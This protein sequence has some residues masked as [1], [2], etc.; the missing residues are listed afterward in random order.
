[1]GRM[2]PEVTR[3]DLLSCRLNLSASSL[4]A[5]STWAR[6]TAAFASDRQPGSAQVP[7]VGPR[8]LLLFDYG[9]KFVFGNS[10]DPSRDL[11]LGFAQSDLA[12]TGSL[13]FTKVKDGDSKSFGDGWFYEGTGIYRHVW[14]ANTNVFHL[15]LWESTVRTNLR[16][17]SATLS[18]ATLV[19]NEGKHAGSA[20]VTWQILEDAG[21]TVAAAQAPAQLVAVDGS[22]GF[23]VAATMTGPKLWSVDEP[24]LYMAIV[25]VES[26]GKARGAERVSFG[27]RTTVFDRPK[28]SF[29]N[30]K[31][32]KIAKLTIITKQVGLR[33]SVSVVRERDDFRAQGDCRAF[34]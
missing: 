3:R 11:N 25:I 12:Q 20:C 31:S 28:S 9:W 18:L 6:T 33:A 21:K 16:S 30:V 5:R 19:G 4:L 7:D 13:D 29:L 2:M 34:S 27:M 8:E 24:N 10:T 15:G 26:G 1:M 32:I 23:T 22:S 17:A 14:L